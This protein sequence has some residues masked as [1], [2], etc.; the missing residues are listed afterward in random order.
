MFKKSKK[1]ISSLEKQTKLD[2]I[3]TI[4]E[5]DASYTVVTE[6]RGEVGVVQKKLNKALGDLGKF[7]KV[8]CGLAYKKVFNRGINRAEDNYDKQ[9]AELHP[10]IYQEGSM[11]CM[12][13]LGIPS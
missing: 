1:K 12:N 7:E 11:A 5:L 13:E 9:L 6:A 10:S 3:T 4:Q 2:L 8:A